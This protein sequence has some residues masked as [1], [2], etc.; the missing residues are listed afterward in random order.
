MLIDTHC[1][2]HDARFDDDRA[3][4]LERARSAGVQ[5]MISI[6]CDLET[7]KRAHALSQ[8]HSDIYFSAGFHPHEAKL[9]DENLIETLR[10]FALKPKCVAIGECGLDYHYDHSPRDIQQKVFAQ[11]VELAGELGKAL[12]VH[13]RDAFDDCL[14][15]LKPMGD[16]APVVIH[17]F[18]GN[19]E[20]AKKMI[21]RGYYIS[22][23]GIVT[24]K[25]PGELD[26]VVQQIPI[27]HLLVET[28]SP[29]LAPLPFRG[30]R[31]EPSYVV[32]V[33]EKVAELRS[34]TLEE[35]APILTLNSKKVFKI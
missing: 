6:G 17:C 18:T 27:E 13:V 25:D 26:K 14:E 31:N 35:V 4:V 7:T 33:A 30:K 29:Y 24:F 16:R 10:A 34:M 9:A 8:L 28:D 23:S 1:H 21:D 12:V 2:I 3:Q 5:T 19:V 20:V 22:I 32:K 11:Q 15:L